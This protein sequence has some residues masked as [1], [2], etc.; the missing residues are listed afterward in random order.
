MKRHGCSII[1]VNDQQQVLLFLRD[2]KPGIAYP[3]MWDVLGGHLE[4]G[5]TPE[6]CIV[7]EMKEELGMELRDFALFCVETFPDRI[8]HTFWKR[9]NMDIRTLTL[10]EGQQLRWFTQQEVSHTPLAGGF[11]HIVQDFFEQKPFDRVSG[12]SS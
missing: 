9:T 4:K 10:T 12:K 6:A 7:R 2:D 11:N 8:E 1:F 3:N 5:E